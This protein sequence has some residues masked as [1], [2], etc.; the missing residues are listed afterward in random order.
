M[1]GEDFSSLLNTISGENSEMTIETT[2]MISEEISN[3][4]TRKINEIW[5][6]LISQIH[7]AITTVIAEKCFVPFKIHL[8]RMGE[9]VSLW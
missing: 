3:Q 6:S 5:S 4:M 7:V 2:R 1:V 9:V 8:V